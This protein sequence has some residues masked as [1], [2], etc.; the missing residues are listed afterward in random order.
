VISKIYRTKDGTEFNSQARALA[1][2]KQCVD[3]ACYRAIKDL[4]KGMSNVEFEHPDAF[5]MDH[6]DELY[7]LL[8]TYFKDTEELT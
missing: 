3:E 1:Y 8:K 4:C 2:Q 5:I 6:K 7:A